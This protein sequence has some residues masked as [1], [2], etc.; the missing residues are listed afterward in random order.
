MCFCCD[1][2]VFFM[3]L[4]SVAPNPFRIRLPRWLKFTVSNGAEPTD[5]IETYYCRNMRSVGALS[6]PFIAFSIFSEKLTLMD[7]FSALLHSRDA[8]YWSECFPFSS[9]YTYH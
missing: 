5:P 6:Y 9:F 2:E 1:L 3:P 7:D 4:V 8:I